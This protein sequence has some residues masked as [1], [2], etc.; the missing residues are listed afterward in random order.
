VLWIDTH[1]LEGH[2]A[3]LAATRTQEL[4]RNQKSVFQTVIIGMTVTFQIFT[5]LPLFTIFPAHSM[6]PCPLKVV[7][8]LK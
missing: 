5:Y 8:I 6:L 1:V 2:A 3:H 4:S 7:P